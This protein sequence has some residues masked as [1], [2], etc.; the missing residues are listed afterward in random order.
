M[1]EVKLSRMDSLPRL[2]KGGVMYLTS[3][4]G[5]ICPT[6]N[7]DL[8]FKKLIPSVEHITEMANCSTW[9]INF[10][11]EDWNLHLAS[12][13]VAQIKTL[14][15]DVRFAITGLWE[16]PINI[17][18]MREQCAAL[19]P[20]ADI[21][22]FID[23]DF[24]FVKDT[25]AYPFSSGQR[26]LHTIDYMTRFPKCGV[27]NTKSFLGGVPQKLKIIPT[28]D[29][30]YATNRGLFLRN[31]APHGFLLAPYHTHHLVG[32]LEETLMTFE[33]IAL[34]FFCARQ[35]NNPT[36]HITGKLSDYDDQPEDFHNIELINENIGHYL[37]WKWGE[38]EWLYE[39]KKFP[40]RL[41]VMHRANGGLD[42]AYKD[43][44]YTIDYAALENWDDSGIGG[45][46]AK[47]GKRDWKLLQ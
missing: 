9:L 37:K 7:V 44:D 47:R 1:L 46:Y 4:I 24:E 10:N 19:Y 12:K 20:E 6:H 29:D 35:M 23:D 13:A 3:T 26:Y 11:G 18:Q 39:E 40:R 30:M 15:F 34:G 28:R 5:I 36:I 43:P 8:F 17:I 16:K 2:I 42:I 32:G 45:K 27:V 41:W 14:G 38:W 31:M 21:Y 33:R 22:M 25:P